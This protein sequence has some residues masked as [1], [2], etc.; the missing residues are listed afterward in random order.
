MQKKLQVN[1]NPPEAQVLN[2]TTTATVDGQMYFTVSCENSGHPINPSDFQ[3]KPGY[4]A[5]Q[6]LSETDDAAK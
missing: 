5:V 4:L 6:L 1:K 2:L 3:P